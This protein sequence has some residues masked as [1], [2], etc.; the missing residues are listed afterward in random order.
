M[1]GIEGARQ[2]IK[3]VLTVDAVNAKI[4]LLNARMRNTPGWEDDVPMLPQRSDPSQNGV[5]DL[6]SRTF[7]EITR[8]GIGYMIA[9]T[10][11]GVVGLMSSGMNRWTMP[12][13]FDCVS[14][15]TDQETAF[16]QAGV[17]YDAVK[18]VLED[19]EGTILTGVTPPVAGV[20]VGSGTWEMLTLDAA[21]AGKIIFCRA[22]HDLTVDDARL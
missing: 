16:Q 10:R 3:Q 21:A 8:P 18:L 17:L 7:R 5:Q 20:L 11:P 4:T 19:F 14:G 15:V 6:W 1:S 12:I 13:V 2:L 9:V 22:V